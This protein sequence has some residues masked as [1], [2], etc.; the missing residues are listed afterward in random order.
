MKRIAIQ[1]ANIL[2][3]LLVAG[4]FDHCLALGYQF[5]TTEMILDEL[6]EQQVAILQ[7]HI[8]SGKLTIISISAEDLE[9]IAGMAN[10]HNRI[11]VQDWSAI[12]Y[13]E[14][15]EALLLSGD[16]LVRKIAT[17]RKLNVCGTL[18]ILDQLV[19][20]SILPGQQAAIFLQ[21]L[22]AKKRRL[23]EAECRARFKLWEDL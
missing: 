20:A 7:P 15:K 17:A 19:D 22:L 13:A 1:D 21:T 9:A 11:S 23:P 18:W 3:D 8:H 12:Y 4:M 6:Y 14:Q 10:E 2:I 5:C 16:G